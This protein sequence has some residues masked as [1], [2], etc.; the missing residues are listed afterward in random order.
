MVQ[1]LGKKGDLELQDT[2]LIVT[3]CKIAPC[4]VRGLMYGHQPLITIQP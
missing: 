4:G 3:G 1:E 2:Y